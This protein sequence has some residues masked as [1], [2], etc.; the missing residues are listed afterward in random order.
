MSD[1][2][3]YSNENGKICLV[4]I[5]GEDGGGLRNPLFGRPPLVQ[6][7]QGFISPVKS[8]KAA[9]H[10]RTQNEPDEAG[11]ES[12]FDQNRTTQRE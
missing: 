3:G 11:N 9:G 4:P 6:L 8:P 12:I 2:S 10:I 7:L 1:T 5:D